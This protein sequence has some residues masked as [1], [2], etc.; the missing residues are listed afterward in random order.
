MIVILWQVTGWQSWVVH[1]C[2]GALF[3]HESSS[4]T[5][6]GGILLVLKWIEVIE[7]FRGCLPFFFI[8]LVVYIVCVYVHDFMKVTHVLTA[9]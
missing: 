2:V 9:P 6:F 5:R 7:W 1:T 4:C 8:V 3:F